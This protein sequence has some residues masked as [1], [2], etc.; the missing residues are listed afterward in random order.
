MDQGTS[1]A[2]TTAVSASP[3]AKLCLSFISFP[4]SWFVSMIVRVWLQAI[5]PDTAA[6]HS[7]AA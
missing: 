1:G 4:Q 6:V 2:T 7:M 5:M 3:S